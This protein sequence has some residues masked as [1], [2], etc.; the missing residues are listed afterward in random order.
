MFNFTFTNRNEYMQQKQE[1]IQAYKEAVLD[2]RKAKLAIR[3]ANR[4]NHYDIYS[5]YAAK[6]KANKHLD[7]L[8][9]ARSLSREEA[10]RQWLASKQRS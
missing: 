6:S 7:E 10:N 2:I 3:H 1:W 5:F 8:L 4:D 9:T